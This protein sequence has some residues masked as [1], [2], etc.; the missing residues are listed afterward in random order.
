M[1][2]PKKYGFTVRYDNKD[3]PV[4]GKDPAGA[5]TL[6]VKLIDANHID[7]TSKKGHEVLYTSKVEVSQD[8]KVMDDNDEGRE[9][10]RRVL[11]QRAGLR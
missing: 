7:S 2:P 1:A 4:T 11:R 10:G 9:L 6:V 8:G 3:Y 5:D